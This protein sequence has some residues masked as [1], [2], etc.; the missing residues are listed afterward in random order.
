M[1]TDRNLPH[2]AAALVRVGDVVSEPARL[3]VKRLHHHARRIC[4]YWLWT[5]KLRFPALHFRRIEESRD[6][7]R[8]LTCLAPFS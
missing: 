2:K 6:G 1:W 8:G 4:S 7:K 5:E 3:A